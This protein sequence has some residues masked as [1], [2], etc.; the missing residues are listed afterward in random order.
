MQ[1]ITSLTR[2]LQLITVNEQLLQYNSWQ[3]S[4][5]AV[6][7][8]LLVRNSISGGAAVHQKNAA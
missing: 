8:G 3:L 4:T 7:D 1:A 5:A 2:V 6:T